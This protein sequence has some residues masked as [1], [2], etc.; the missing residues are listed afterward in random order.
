[1]TFHSPPKKC[2]PNATQAVSK[3]QSVACYSRSVLK[4][5]DDEP[6]RGLVVKQFEASR[7][8]HIQRGISMLRLTLT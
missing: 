5:Y 6:W 1:L 3:L 4:P 2:T 8:T 7:I